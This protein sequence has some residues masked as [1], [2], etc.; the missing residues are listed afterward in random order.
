MKKRIHS[1]K[2]TFDKTT[3]ANLSNGDMVLLRAGG[4]PTDIGYTCWPGGPCKTFDCQ[5]PT[6]DNGRIV[7]T[8]KNPC[9]N[10]HFC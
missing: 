5:T 7:A 3:V 10:P 8:I 6:T 4:D 1:K 9:T 2:L